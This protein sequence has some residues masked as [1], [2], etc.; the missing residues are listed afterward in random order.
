MLSD[1][2]TLRGIL[3]LLATIQFFHLPVHLGRVNHWL[4]PQDSLGLLDRHSGEPVQSF[5][6]MARDG[7]HNVC[8]VSVTVAV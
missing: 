4:F 2:E 5:P 1:I 8:E 6:I 3:K 7:A